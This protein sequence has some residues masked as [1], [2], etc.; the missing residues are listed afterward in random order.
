MLDR[1]TRHDVGAR[2]GD[3]PRQVVVVGDDGRAVGEFDL[4]PVEADPRRAEPPCPEVPWHSAHPF[5]LAMSCPRAPASDSTTSLPSPELP[6]AAKPATTASSRT[7]PAARPHR[8]ELGG[9]WSHAHQVARRRS[10]V[11]GS[12][13][14]SGSIAPQQVA[15]SPRDAGPHGADRTTEHLS[16]LVVVQAEHLGEHERRP[17]VRVERRHQVV[18]IDST[19]HVR[20]RRAFPPSNRS[21]PRASPG[22]RG[23]V[24]WSI[25][26][27]GRRRCG[28]RS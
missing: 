5:D 17:T 23:A 9:R 12:P 3:R 21:S 28:E 27:C 4:G 8:V 22:D 13:T 26:G 19:G 1:C 10:I 11:P 7:G 18:E 16:R 15:T 20:R 24:A 6:Q 2:V 14:C 25:G